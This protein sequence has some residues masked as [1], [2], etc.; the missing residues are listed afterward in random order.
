MSPGRTTHDFLVVPLFRF[1]DLRDLNHLEHEDS[2]EIVVNGRAFRFS[3]DVAPV[4]ELILALGNASVK[5]I[6]DACLPSIP[7]ERCA[8]FLAELVDC[9]AICLKEPS[10][11]DSVSSL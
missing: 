4:L 5:S 8:E 1:P 7:L 11:R 2:F 3:E 6:L 9:G 10:G